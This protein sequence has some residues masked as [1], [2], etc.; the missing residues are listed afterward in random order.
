M[1]VHLLKKTLD[2]ILNQLKINDS[3]VEIVVLDSASDDG[4]KELIFDLK[5][6]DF[7]SY[8]YNKE[9]RGIDIDLNESVEIS[10]GRYCW[11]VSD[12]DP[13]V[14]RSIEIVKRQFKNDHDIYLCSNF[15]C[16]KNLNVLFEK[17]WLKKMQKILLFK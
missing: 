1:R 11:L 9:K 17:H 12:D 3:D 13:H 10:N 2:S 15:F 8:K 16:D 7:I 5:K 14:S 6:F 4:T